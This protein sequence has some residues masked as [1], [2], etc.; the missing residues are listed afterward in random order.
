MNTKLVIILLVL[1]VASFGI[2][3]IFGIS[4][5][6]CGLYLIALIAAIGTLQRMAYAKKLIVE[7]EKKGTLLPYIKNKKER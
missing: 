2:T 5:I 3:N 1:L 4:I 6:E 7:A